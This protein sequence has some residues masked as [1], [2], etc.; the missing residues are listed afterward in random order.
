MR[1]AAVAAALFL[2]CVPAA[3]AGASPLV[4][5]ATFGQTAVQFGDAIRAQV[6]VVLDGERVNAGSLRL[7]DDL[8]PLTPLSSASTTRTTKAGTTI[9]TV[10]RT[11]SCMSSAC[12]APGGTAT[13]V[14]PH[15]TATVSTSAGRTLRVT[16]AW[17]DLRVG[18]RVGKADL[19]RTRPPFRADTEPPAPSYRLAPSTLAWLLDGVAI[20][21]AA[22]AAVLLLAT[23]R[24][25][26]RRRT[27]A[28][29]DELERA[30]RLAREAER[31]LPPDRRRALGLLARL[32]DA[33]DRDLSGTARNLAWARPEPERDTLASFVT[34]VEREVES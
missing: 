33:R 10:V 13:P 3:S 32:L 8:G 16:S 5:R 7:V 29:V 25:F 6:V 11:V 14:L 23:A 30:L 21:L 12:V 18:G 19:A 20:A 31:R 15:V 27:A 17:P 9:V 24:R 2:A 4:V 34:D 1:R 28:P 26:A 22:A